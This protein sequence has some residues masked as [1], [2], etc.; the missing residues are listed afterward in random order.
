VKFFFENF[1]KKESHT[2]RKMASLQLDE[3]G[4]KKNA[5]KE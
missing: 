5:A 1:Q 2:N 4:F 3:G